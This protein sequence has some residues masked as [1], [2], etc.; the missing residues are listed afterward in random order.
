MTTVIVIPRGFTIVSPGRGRVS[1]RTITFVDTN[2]PAKG[3]RT[4]TL[5]LRPA[6]KPRTAKAV[7]TVAVAGSSQVQRTVLRIKV[8]APRAERTAVT[9]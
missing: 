3:R 7:V 4:H 5:Y 1:G 8:R 9:G 6:G 2:V